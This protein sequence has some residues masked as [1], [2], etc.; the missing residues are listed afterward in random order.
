MNQVTQ[1]SNEDVILSQLEAQTII[2]M[3][4]YDVMFAL[5]QQENTE[6]ARELLQFHLDGT[7]LGPMPAF[8]GTF[9]VNEL[10]DDATG[11]Q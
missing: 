1:Q 2:L 8:N 11:D 6:L 5:L 3:R 7:I 4:I 10:N 9:A